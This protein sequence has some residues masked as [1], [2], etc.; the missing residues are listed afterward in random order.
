MKDKG[1]VS[2]EKKPATVDWAGVRR[3]VEE[4]GTALE[5]GW[6]PT[7]EEKRK[8]FKMRAKALAQETKEEETAEEYIEVVEFMLAYEK[9]G[10]DSSYV[11]EIYP[12]KELTPVP[13]TPIFVL[14]IVNVRGEILSVIDIKKFFDLPEKGLGDLNKVIVLRSGSPV[15]GRAEGLEF[16]ILADV[17]LGVRA[18]PLNEIQPSLPTLT[19]IREEYLKGI[20]KDRAVILDAGKLLSDKAIIVHEDVRI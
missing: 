16:G 3:R 7:P 2:P 20:T 6:S 17:I 15:P 9:Y 5:K 11:R 13:C 19:G 4:A 12:L 8:I 18:V 10:I 1:R 14:G